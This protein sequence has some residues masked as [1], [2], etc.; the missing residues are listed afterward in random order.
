MIIRQCV[1]AIFCIAVLWVAGLHADEVLPHGAQTQRVEQDVREPVAWVNAEI[2]NIS[3]MLVPCYPTVQR[4]NGMMRFLPPNDDFLSSRTDGFVMGTFAHRDRRSGGFRLWPW[5]GATDMPDGA[6]PTELDQARVTPFRYRVRLD[7]IDVVL[8]YAPAEKSAVFSF[9]FESEGTRAL[10][11]APSAKEGSVSWNGGVLRGEDRFRTRTVWMVGEFDTPVVRTVRCGDRLAV[12]FPEGARQVRMRYAFSLISSDQASANLK[13]EIRDFDIDRIAAEG[14]AAWNER[15]GAVRV[16][17]GNDNQKT[18]FYT[19]LWRTFERMVDFTEDG[20]YI[21]WDGKVHDAGKSRYYSDDWV[22]DTYRAHHP[23]MV[24]LQPEAEGDKLTSY[25]RMASQNPEGWMPTFPNVAL[26]AHSMNGFHT[27]AVFLDAWRKGVRNFDLAAAYAACAKTMRE[28]TK[29]PWLRARKNELDA[30]YDEHGYFPALA[31]GEKETVRGVSGWEKRQAVTV[32]LAASYDA[33]CLAELAKEVG[34]AEGEREFRAQAGNYMKLWKNDAGFFHPR[35]AKGNWIEP[36]DYKFSGGIGSRAYYDENN[37]WT[38]LWDVQHD[39]PGLV[40]LFGGKRPFL[41]KLDQLFTEPL[42]CRR[43]LWPSKQ[44]DSSGMMGQFS[45]GN[46]PSFHIPYLFAL[47]G[48]PAKTQ[49]KIRHILE[50]WFRN[51]LMGVPGDE[52]GGGMSAFVVFSMLGFYPVTPGLPEYVIGSPVFTRAEI[53]R[54]GS[55][56]IVISAPASSKYAKYVKSVAVGGRRLNGVR[57]T[58]EQLASGS[59]ITFEMSDRP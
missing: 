9:T 35:D 19:A 51:D 30:F 50:A 24:L 29:T 27:V 57:L 42:G 17:G 46:E 3:H 43:F 22:W 18:V 54:P 59:P 39:I 12:V 25:I 55:V 10:V 2:G 47:A 8:D 36:F 16:E 48:E 49:K 58:H 44:P 38:Y 53:R 40:A 26:D 15:L 14:Q 33:W 45:M 13:A 32:T 28:T 37:A 6:W 4:P 41:K 52:D 7:D 1:K 11:F 34:D 20:K 56:P 23:L 5:L 31:E 21:G